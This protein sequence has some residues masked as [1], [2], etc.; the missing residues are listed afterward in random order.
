MTPRY[1]RSA[2]LFLVRFNCRIQEAPK[3]TQ[4]PSRSPNQTLKDTQEAPGPP[5]IVKIIHMDKQEN[6]VF[7]EDENLIKK[8]T[9]DMKLM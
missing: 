5:I 2:I 9:W 6:E 4:E 7:K 3:A 8:V 1:C